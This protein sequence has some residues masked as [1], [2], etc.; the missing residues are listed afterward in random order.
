MAGLRHSYDIERVG[1]TPELTGDNKLFYAFTRWGAF[2][3]A[4]Y[5]RETE[6]FFTTEPTKGITFTAS[7][8]TRSF[9]PL[10][11]FQYRLNPEMGLIRLYKIIIKTHSLHWRPGLRKTRRF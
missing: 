1:L 2:S 3:G 10:F 5:R 8:N 6:A 11:R 4:F 7:A 9:D